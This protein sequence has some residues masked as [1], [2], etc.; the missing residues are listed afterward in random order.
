MATL[1]P[2]LVMTMDTFLGLDTLLPHQNMLKDKRLL[3]Y[4]PETMDNRVL[5]VSHQWTSFGEA[6]HTG[7][8]IQTLQR[9]LRRLMAGS[10]SKV[11][12]N[13]QQRVTLGTNEVVTAAQWKMALPHMF[14]WVR[15]LS[16][17]PISATFVICPAHATCQKCVIPELPCTFGPLG[18]PQCLAPHV[19]AHSSL[20]SLAHPSPV[21]RA[22]SGS[23]GLRPPH[24]L[25]SQIDFCCMPQPIGGP[26]SEDLIPH[27]I[28]GKDAQLT[29]EEKA[30]LKANFD[31]IDEDFSGEVDP[32]EFKAAM[33]LA[34]AER[35][36]KMGAPSD[37]ALDAEFKK[38]DTDGS[39]T[40]SLEEFYAVFVKIKR[41]EDTGSLL[42]RIGGRWRRGSSVPLKFARSGGVEGT[43]SFGEE[44]RANNKF[45]QALE[46]TR[47]DSFRIASTR[48]RSGRRSAVSIDDIDKCCDTITNVDDGEDSDD[49]ETKERETADRMESFRSH[50]NLRKSSVTDHRHQGSVGE[51]PPWLIH[52]KHWLGEAVKSIAAY[53]ERS[54]LV[55]ILVPNCEHGDLKDTMCDMSSWRGRGWCRL[56][57]AGAV[58]ARTNVRLMVVRGPEVDPEFIFPADS[59]MLAPGRG[60]YSV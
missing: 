41:G 13:W 30:H 45:M 25:R 26:I 12:T 58:L 10:I 51:E 44:K 2:M 17:P 49:D 33:R 7:I 59:L 6:D 8:Q 56:E 50:F 53:I 5:F 21:R 57:L 55:I 42:G 15:L 20:R 23:V 27:E 40:I 60:F 38:C 19:F 35:Q 36:D 54:A 28:S 48:S 32:D 1:Y 11:A 34:F 31:S 16:P 9:V 4:N 29:E 47:A 39:G 18:C 43:M 22:P 37:E 46:E 3:P 24:L 14:V 52:V